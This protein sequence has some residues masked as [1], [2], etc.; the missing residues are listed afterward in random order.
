MK[1]LYIILEMIFEIVIMC[2]S[3]GISAFILTMIVFMI[4]R[5]RESMIINLMKKYNYKFH[6]GSPRSFIPREERA[7]FTNDITSQK[8]YV[9]GVFNIKYKNLKNILQ[10]R[11]RLDIP[12]CRRV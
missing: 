2:A 10:S 1:I 9:D 6:E 3:V 4:S 5:I 11:G 8:I 12:E 7:Y